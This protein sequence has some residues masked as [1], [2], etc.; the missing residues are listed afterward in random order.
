MRLIMICLLLTACGQPVA[1]GTET[2]AT[3]CEALLKTAPSAS[4]SDTP[5]TLEEVAR[6]GDV[7]DTLCK[8]HQP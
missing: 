2:K 8:E 6:V 3:W 1:F 4:L 7:I 5:Q